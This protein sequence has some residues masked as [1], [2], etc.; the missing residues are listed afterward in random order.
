MLCLCVLF[1][2]FAAGHA[3]SQVLATGAALD[4]K[5]TSPTAITMSEAGP[6]VKGI[7]GIAP[8]P[9]KPVCDRLVFYVDDQV[10]LAS[11]EPSPRL[12]LDTTALPDGEHTLRL[13]AEAGGK[14]VYSSGTIR[15][16]VANK[17]GS[18]VAGA[19]DRMAENPSAPPYAKTFRAVISQEAIWFNGTEGDLE[20]HAFISKGRMYITLNDL[21]RHIGGHIVWGPSAKYI[22]VTRNDTTVHLIPGSSKATVNGRPVDLR[23]PVTVRDGLTYVPARALCELFGIYIE[24]NKAERRAYVATPQPTYGIEARSYPWVTNAAGYHP[25]PGRVVFKNNSGVPVHVLLQGNGYRTD[26]QVPAMGSTDAIPLPA[27]TY[28]VT[29]WSRGGEDFETYITTTAGVTDSY[30]I[31]IGSIVR[32]KS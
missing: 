28:R 32:R 9:I 2:A 7:L 5:I 1:A 17:A 25:E 21:M 22:D 6:V 24:Y 27:G 16:Q 4:V 8:S 10:K 11:T 12:D 15:F 18:A 13:E 26:I 30:D 23:M 20:R 14:L 3:D 19:F 31:S 29:V